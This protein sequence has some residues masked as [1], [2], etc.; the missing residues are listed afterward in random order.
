MSGWV[1]NVSSNDLPG[2]TCRTTITF[3]TMQADQYLS[4]EQMF[5]LQKRLPTWRQRRIKNCLPFFAKNLESFVYFL[6]PC[7]FIQILPA[8]VVQMIIK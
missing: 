8:Y 7:D 3:G 5:I 6:P 1:C 4:I 2:Y